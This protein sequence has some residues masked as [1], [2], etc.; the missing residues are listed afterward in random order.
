MVIDVA[1]T[2]WQ[3]LLDGVQA[4]TLWVDEATNRRALI[5]QF[6]PGAALARHV[7]DGDEVLFVL[8]GAVSDDH[9]T[10]EAGNAGYRPPGCTHT[11]RSAAGGTSLALISG[12][13]N[14]VQD[15][16][17]G[18]PPSQVIAVADRAEVEVRPGIFQRLLW[19]DRASNR[20]AMLVRYGPGA[21]IPRHRHDGDELIYVLEG[22]VDD[23]HGSVTAGNVG[24]RPD[25]CVHQVSAPG[26]ARVFALVRGGID[27][28]A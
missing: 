6:S 10:V 13:I 25:G 8:D 2:P 9:G 11:V 22:T 28:V 12:G 3:R 14:P 16:V 23:D 26:G 27:P 17:T 20:Q 24:F 21:T 1:A 5:V 4:K 19:E 18:G 15:E 7:H